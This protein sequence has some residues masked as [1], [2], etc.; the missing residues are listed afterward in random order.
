MPDSDPSPQL[1]PIPKELKKQLA[2]FQRQLWRT[3]IVE[4]ILAGFFGLIISFLVVF[5][6]DRF[7]ATPP[8]A[9]LGILIA[10]TSLF[11]IFA[12]LM[13]RRWIYGHRK[14][15]QLAHLISKKFPKL[16]DRLLGVVEL[17]DQKESH[18]TL[19]PELR[20]AAMAHV[21]RQ[22]GKKD[23][24]EALPISH[25][26]KL[27]LGV[28]LGAL[29]VIL[30]FSF[31]PKAGSNALKRWLLPLSDTERYTFTQLDLSGLPD[32]YTV[33]YDEPFVIIVPLKE[34]T[35]DRPEIAEA[36][37]GLQDWLETDL[38]EKGY[39]FEFQGQQS[40]DVLTLRVG[41]ALHRI[42]IEPEIRP[43]LTALDAKVT[44]PAYLQLE[45]KTI[46][47][48]SGTLSALAGSTIK[49][50]GTFSRD[51]KSATGT[52]TALPSDDEVVSTFEE[53]SE[54]ETEQPAPLPDPTPLKLTI[55]EDRITSSPIELGEF[56]VEIPLQWTDV[57]GLESST[58]FNLKIQTAHD[59]APL[60]YTQGIERQIVILA[61]ET[62]EFEVMTED[63]Y[64]IQ[65][66]GLMWQGEFTKP[67]DESP[68]S[69]EL[70]LK[71]GSPSNSRL[72]ELAIFSPKTHGIVPQKLTLVGYAQD[73]KPERERSL[74]E[75]I[76]IYIL[77][78]DEHAQLLKQRFDRLIG[79]LEDAARREQ[80]NLDTNERLDQ[81]N[82]PEDLQNEE[83]K[84]KLAQQEDAEDQN[85]EKMEEIAKKME[86]LFKDA[87][88]NKSIEKETMKKMADSLQNMKELAKQDL[89][90]IE[91][92]L[93]ESQ[94]N[95]ST[96]EKAKKDLQEAIEKQKEALK[97]MQE[98]IKK[99]NEANN[100]FEASTFINRLKRA[101][102]DED[103]I[104]NKLV[105]SMTGQ[106]SES[107]KAA[108]PLL[109]AAAESD[110]FD[111]VFRRMIE[112]LGTQ[113][114]R[115]GSD[116]NWIQEDLANFYART[117]KE[118]HKEIVDDMKRSEISLKLEGLQTRISK[119]RSFTAALEA[120]KWGA[121]L[122]EWAKKLEGTPPDAAGG[123]GGGE[124]GASPEEKDFEFMLK[125]MRM[126]QAEQD[127]RS[128]TR[129]LEQLMRSVE[130]RK[131][132]QN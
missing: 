38:G 50:E 90:E 80:N 35:D 19:S 116:V 57:K 98:T 92:K 104:S 13:M 68:A 126:V 76:I 11:A 20:A 110:T 85:A 130:L 72:S 48:R 82:K 28:A 9:R 49:L 2:E 74:S 60:V 46:D 132:G 56:R 95:K 15:G 32:P 97:K 75:P 67:T 83:N 59:Q 37:Y 105:S 39:R 94:D 5:V 114:R 61:G 78:E 102:S 131:A 70:L 124:G 8:L 113:Q 108:T 127:I 101:A 128:R 106:N 41:D 43:E 69:G 33:P 118:I 23:M 99:A 42:R 10:G 22:A 123:D 65:E 27:G 40:R 103:G 73:F 44:L 89:P 4:A 87:A 79:E 21:A 12:P 119:N 81:L 121:Q 115:T 26:K 64:G 36:R 34:E 55:S 62:L 6:L 96:P 24:G 52:V 47:I 71:Q 14:E 25:Y 84:E 100:N 125:V 109:G 53:A 16:G 107:K 117:Q 63:D 30:G 1:T 7:I 129:S 91:K 58:S 66:I 18:K 88:R 29:C 120:K 31:A 45:P 54:T 3:K 86:E 77:T 122:R 51:L 17:Q 93:N 111:P 112:M